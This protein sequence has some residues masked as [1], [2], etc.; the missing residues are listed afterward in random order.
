MASIKANRIDDIVIDN[1]QVLTFTDNHESCYVQATFD[2]HSR[3]DDGTIHLA[4]DDCVQVGEWL[5]AKGKE[6]KKRKI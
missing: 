3:N 4:A 5:I 6:L 2:E 1:G